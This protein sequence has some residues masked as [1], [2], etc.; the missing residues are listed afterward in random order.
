MAR[1]HKNCKPCCTE[2]FLGK[3]RKRIN[4]T[5]VVSVTALAGVLNLVNQVLILI[6][7]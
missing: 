2:C 5:A 6:G 7:R 3:P 1:K 4:D